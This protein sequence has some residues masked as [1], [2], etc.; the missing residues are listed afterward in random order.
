M[1][2]KEKAKDIFFYIAFTAGL[3]LALYTLVLNASAL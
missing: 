3:M 1:A 2:G